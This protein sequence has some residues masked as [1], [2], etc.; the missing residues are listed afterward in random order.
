MVLHVDRDTR[1]KEGQLA[2]T[3]HD[4]VVLEFLGGDEDFR[5]R[6]ESDLR[7]GAL[8]L[9]NDLDRLR[10]FAAAELHLVDFAFAA[11]FR[12]EAVGECVDAL[13]ADAV[14]TAGH[15]IGTLIELTTSV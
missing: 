11:D 12:D 5:I 8:R 3:A 9:A 10:D 14:E 15:L 1:D 6:V 13:R 4:R 2:H 7:A